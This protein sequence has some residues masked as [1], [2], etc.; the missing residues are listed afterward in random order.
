MK[1]ISEALNNGGAR[2]VLQRKGINN[3]DIRI[4]SCGHVFWVCTVSN[5]YTSMDDLGKANL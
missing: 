5:S 2:I 3:M 1:V 4:R